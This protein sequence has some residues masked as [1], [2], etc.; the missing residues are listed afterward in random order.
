MGKYEQKEKMSVLI[1]DR[2]KKCAVTNCRD[3]L[4]LRDILDGW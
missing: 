4:Y 2:C 1:Q 3:C